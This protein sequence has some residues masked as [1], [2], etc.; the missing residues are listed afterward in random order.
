[1]QSLGDRSPMDNGDVARFPR[2]DLLRVGDVSARVPVGA[3]APGGPAMFD[4]QIAMP[5]RAV[6]MPDRQVAMLDRD[7]AMPDR[8]GAMRDPVVAMLDRD[9]AVPD[10]A[11]SMSLRRHRDA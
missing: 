9:G 8:D 6:A 3:M 2:R 10:P 1:M 4:R 11:V 5:D 7:G